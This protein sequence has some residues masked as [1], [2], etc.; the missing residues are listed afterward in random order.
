MHR[1][2]L[3]FC[4]EH[5]QQD[6]LQASLINSK[7]FGGNNA[8]AVAL[9]GSVTEAMLR[10][11]HGNKAMSAWQSARDTTLASKAAYRHHCLTEAPAPVYKFNEGV[12]GDE[13]VSLT[14]DAVQLAGGDAMAFN[15]DAGLREFQLDR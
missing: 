13:Q 14:R 5:Q 11:R 12:M 6:D 3:N 7:G 4:L 10:Q 1:Q 8:T 2:H 15:D 9:S